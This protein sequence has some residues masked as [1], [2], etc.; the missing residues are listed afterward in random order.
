[1]ILV[2]SEH[3]FPYRLRDP[4][5]DFNLD[6]FNGY[7]YAGE[8]P[9]KEMYDLLTVKWGVESNVAVT[10]INIYGGHIY[11]IKEALSRLYLERE[12]FDYLFD[13]NLTSNVQ[14]CLDWRF[15][16]E[17]DNV[18]M[19]ETLR[20]LAVT[21]FVLLEKINDPIAKV[22]SLNNVGGVV[23]KS[24]IVIGLNR[25]VWQGTKIKYG[26]VPSKQS[27]RL[28]IAESLEE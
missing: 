12:S 23:K 8:V 26:I 7:I 27:M 19:R 4:K 21:G 15:E 28:V 18:R 1:V 10:L 11:D 20:Q 5:V 2:S 16:K 6:N 25:Q 13:S 17:E 24:G 22:I 3:A 9:P 14:Q